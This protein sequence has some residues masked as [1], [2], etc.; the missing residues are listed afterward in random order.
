MNLNDQS[1]RPSGNRSQGY[2][3]NQI[4]LPCAVTGIAYNRKMAESFDHRNSSHVKCETGEGL[5]A[6]DSTLT[7]NHFLV[8]TSHHIFGCQ[9]PLFVGRGQT[10]L[11]HDGLTKL[12]NLIK[13]VVVLHVPRA[14]LQDICVLGHCVYIFH[15]HDL[16]NNRKT[17]FL[18]CSLEQ[19]QAIFS[20]SSKAVRGGPRLKSSTPHHCG[21]RSF[22]SSGSGDH[23][24]FIFNR[25]RAGH[26]YWAW[27]P[28]HGIPNLYYGVVR[29]KFLA[30][31]FIGLRN[32]NDFQNPIH[33]LHLVFEIRGYR[34]HDSDYCPFNP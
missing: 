14:N 31:Q 24:L 29:M 21:S 17:G 6:S 10:A 23:L 11:D 22:H 25:A 9:Q 28:D 30:G 34:P 7:E 33:Q 3:S 16:G 32:H 13:K 1:V 27:P 19:L 26:D 5:K 4:P 20:H 2:W 15:R 8:P 18:L 12:A